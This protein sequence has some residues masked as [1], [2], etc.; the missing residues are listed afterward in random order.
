MSVYVCAMAVIGIKNYKEIIIYKLFL[1]NYVPLIIRLY[2]FKILKNY[3]YFII[4]NKVSS[5]NNL[6]DYNFTEI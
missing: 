6:I 4:F 1:I 5:L 2:L 3:N